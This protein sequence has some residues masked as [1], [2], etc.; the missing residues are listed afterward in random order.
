MIIPAPTELGQ[1]QQQFTQLL[2]LPLE[3]IASSAR[4][5]TCRYDARLVAAVTDS[6]RASAAASLA[7]YHRQYW[8]RLFDVMQR[9]FALSARLFGLPGFYKLAQA[10]LLDCPPRHPNLGRVADGFVSWCTAQADRIEGIV[11]GG[12]LHQA[13]SVD[14]AWRGIWSAAALPAFEPKPDQAAQLP[15]MQLQFSPTAALIAEDW[16]LIALRRELAMD[17]SADEI[18]FPSK[19][20]ST[21][22]WVLLRTPEGIGQM[23]LSP[24]QSRL[25][26]LCSSHQLQDA[27]ERLHADCEPADRARLP[28]NIRAWLALSMELKLWAAAY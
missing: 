17:A 24:L 12:M 4:A 22:Y 9:E 27:V 21:S 28:E 11:P 6:P 25:Y 16:P 2:R 5:D 7:V 19:L 3:L 23:R 10:Y 14:A 15:C 1:L 20:Q 18:A 8:L 26:T 13:L